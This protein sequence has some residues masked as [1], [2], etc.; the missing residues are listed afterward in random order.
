MRDQEPE[1]D[2]DTIVVMDEI[3][4][5]PVASERAASVRLR[6]SNDDRRRY[7]AHFE[8]PQMKVLLM[9]GFTDGMLVLNRDDIFSQRH[10]SHHNCMP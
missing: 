6:D 8:H 1:M 10:S 9:S 5:F 2:N 4:S 3:P 7:L